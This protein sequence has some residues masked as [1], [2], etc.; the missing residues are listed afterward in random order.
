MMNIK[1]LC[2]ECIHYEEAGRLCKVSNWNTLSNKTVNYNHKVHTRGEW[3]GNFDRHITDEEFT[4]RECDNFEDKCEVPMVGPQPIVGAAYTEYCVKCRECGV[5]PD[6]F[7][8]LAKAFFDEYYVA[9][10]A[11]YILTKTKKLC[12]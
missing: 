1:G 9:G 11:E 10:L 2:L 5:P 8:T 4:C 3:P 7:D 6:M 12:A